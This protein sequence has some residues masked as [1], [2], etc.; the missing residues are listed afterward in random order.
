MKHFAKPLLL[1][2][3][4]QHDFDLA[5]APLRKAASQQGFLLSSCSRMCSCQAS[6]FKEMVEK[7][8]CCGAFLHFLRMLE[9]R[10]PS[11][12]FLDMEK[13]LRHQVL[14]GYLDSSLVNVLET[15]VPSASLDEV[16][17]F[18]RDKSFRRH[19]IR[20]ENCACT[21]SL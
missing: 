5:P 7:H 20:L 3:R 4:I 18:R 21:N 12:A 9:A 13:Q 8:A 15:A 10:A 2:E 14:Y 16:P 17:S 19:H 11:A 6:T 1:V